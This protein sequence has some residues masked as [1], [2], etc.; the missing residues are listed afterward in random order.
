MLT[1]IR[2]LITR[3]NIKVGKL[4]GKLEP[5]HTAI[6]LGILVVLLLG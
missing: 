3:L 1:K 6:L 4:L 2:Q 5:Y